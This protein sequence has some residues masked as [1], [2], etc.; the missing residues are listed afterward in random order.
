MGRRGWWGGA[1]K[2]SWFLRRISENQRWSAMKNGW[3]SKQQEQL[4]PREPVS[5]CAEINA[6]E[7]HESPPFPLPFP[8]HPSKPSPLLVPS[9]P[10]VRPGTPQ[11]QQL[12]LWWIDAD[13]GKSGWIEGLEDAGAAF[14]AG[15]QK[16]DNRW[17]WSDSSTPIPPSTCSP[18]PTLYLGAS[19]VA[20]LLLLWSFCHLLSISSGPGRQD[21]SL[22]GVLSFLPHL[23]PLCA[24]VSLLT[25]SSLHPSSLPLLHSPFSPLTVLSPFIFSLAAAAP[26]NSSRCFSLVPPSFLILR[27][28]YPPKQWLPTAWKLSQW[29]FRWSNNTNLYFI[30]SFYE[31]H[32]ISCHIYYIYYGCKQSSVLTATNITWWETTYNLVVSLSHCCLLAVVSLTLC[33]LNQQELFHFTS[34]LF[35]P[36]HATPCIF[37]SYLL[38]ANFISPS[39]ITCCCVRRSPLLFLWFPLL[40]PSA[41]YYSLPSLFH[42]SISSP[43]VA[44]LL[45][46]C[47]VKDFLRAQVKFIEARA[48]DQTFVWP[49]WSCELLH[50]VSHCYTDPCNQWFQRTLENQGQQDHNPAGFFCFTKETGRAGFPTGGFNFWCLFVGWTLAL[51][52]ASQVGILKGESCD[53]HVQLN[54]HI[55]RFVHENLQICF[56]VPHLKL[57]PNNLPLDLY[58]N[59][60]HKYKV[61]SQTTKLL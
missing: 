46:Y 3:R 12:C 11:N 38:S 2:I 37:P 31:H 40:L 43:A 9:Y 30:I 15:C 58:P 24:W 6:C 55:C 32:W 33:C 52:L 53:A 22:A 44:T 1:E 47:S 20:F 39:S 41:L 57:R 4:R 34:H 19:V 51:A 42:N 45:R 29:S 54:M 48:A 56:G 61:K 25:L 60:L 5:W 27:L 17:E 21:L 59:S 50:S 26:A 8:L 7:V 10:P 13:E 14:D 35:P 49:I 18:S 16:R 23:C 36:L 28:N